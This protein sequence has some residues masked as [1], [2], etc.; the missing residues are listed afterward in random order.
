M[1]TSDT[2]TDASSPEPSSPEKKGR[3]EAPSSSGRAK[4]KPR[5]EEGFESVIVCWSTLQENRSRGAGTEK[6][7]AKRAGATVHLTS[8]TA[9]GRTLCGIRVNPR[10]WDYGIA[11]PEEAGDP[12]EKVTCKRCRLVMKSRGEKEKETAA[13]PSSSS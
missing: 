7:Q 11:L 1:P 12:K 6:K 3:P 10:T 4:E 5:S 13:P 8:R 9:G 2:E